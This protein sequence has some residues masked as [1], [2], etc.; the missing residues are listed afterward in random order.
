MYRTAAAAL[1]THQIELPSWAFRGA[2]VRFSG[3][4]APE[5][6]RTAYELLADAAVVHRFTGLTPNVGLHLPVDRADDYADLARH[7]A[8]LGLTIG[9]IHPEVNLRQGRPPGICHAEEWIRRRA[10]EQLLDA[11]E[12]A[13]AVHARRLT[14]RFVDD[15]PYPGQDELHA[16]RDRL[17]AAL[18]EVYAELPA[19]I[20]L[21][22]EYAVIEPCYYTMDLPDWGNA[23]AQSLALGPAAQ[24]LVDAGPYAQGRHPDLVVELLRRESRL[25][26]VVVPSPSGAEADPFDLFL[27]MIELATADA[28]GAPLALDP[29]ANRRP[30]ILPL[31]R[32]VLA[33][34]EAAARAAQLDGEAWRVAHAEGAQEQAHA[35]LM[36]AYST[37]VTATLAAARG[38]LGVTVD[39]IAAYEEACRAELQAAE[40]RAA[41]QRVHARQAAARH[42]AVERRPAPRRTAEAAPAPAR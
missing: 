15:S 6:P 38:R 23:Y 27:V 14:L 41:E 20:R 8:E 39:P 31:I 32:S 29:G 25:G 34:Q 12:V 9:S 11:V 36:A 42:R 19:G 22:I 33:M 10:L 28:G 40:R 2:D 21:V 4:T 30:G 18:S 24:V 3:W 1:V 37:D 7:A 16:R 5:A 26:G 17:T 13:A 35:L